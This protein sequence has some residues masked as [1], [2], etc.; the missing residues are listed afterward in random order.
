[1]FTR[2]LGTSVPFVRE[3]SFQL[4]GGKKSTKSELIKNSVA[5]LGLTEADIDENFKLKLM[6]TAQIRKEVCFFVAYEEL[7]HLLF[8]TENAERFKNLIESEIEGEWY[9]TRLLCMSPDKMYVQWGD[10]NVDLL[11]DALLIIL[12]KYGF[13]I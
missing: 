10:T 8:V 11:E 3:K 4:Q 7:N 6:S 12:N 2:E 9:F 1:M 5:K 13:Q